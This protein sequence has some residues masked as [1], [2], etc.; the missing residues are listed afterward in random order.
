MTSSYGAFHSPKYP[1]TVP[2][3]QTDY[4]NDK[5]S[6]KSP[7][8]HR[9][10]RPGIWLLVACLTVAIL[11]PLWISRT[12]HAPADST[13][14]ETAAQ[15]S[16]GTADP[17]ASTDRESAVAAAPQTT[18]PGL[19]TARSG[20]QAEDVTGLDPRLGTTGSDAAPVFLGPDGAPSTAYAERTAQAV[21]RAFG[22]PARPEGLALAAP[23]GSATPIG[24]I[25]QTAVAAGA[26]DSAG[27]PGG[28]SGVDAYRR[29]DQARRALVA[30]MRQVRRAML[31]EANR[32]TGTNQ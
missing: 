4:R 21:D 28:E 32:R 9:G 8:S 1:F 7:R 5:P 30:E 27:G 17:S 23:A 25:P 13:M 10:I 22:A 26:P 20:A 6:M 3:C 19:G 24:S 31:V 16:V 29:S 12:R 2:S 15:Q 11:I 14:N 18:R